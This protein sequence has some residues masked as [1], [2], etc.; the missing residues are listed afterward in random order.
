[1][2]IAHANQETGSFTS[3][4]TAWTIARSIAVS[5]D[6]V[7]TLS[8]T[9]GGGTGT[10]VTPPS[11]WTLIAQANSGTTLATLV[12]RKV[13][14]NGGT[15]PSSYAFVVN[16]A[17]QG[18]WGLDR[19][20][21]VDLTTQLSGT[22][23]TNSG[24]STSPAGTAM[25]TADANAMVV[26][27]MGQA[28]G[29]AAITPPSGMAEAWERVDRC[30]EL[31]YVLQ[32][33]AG[34]TGTKT[35][36]ST[37]NITW[38]VVVFALK[39]AVAPTASIA[40][41][42]ASIFKSPCNWFTS[43]SSYM[44]TNYGGAYFRIKWTGTQIDMAVDVSALT[45]AGI[46]AGSYPKI[47]YT[48]DNGAWSGP[49]QLTSATTSVTLASGLTDTAHEVWMVVTDIGALAS[50]DRWTTPVAQV[51]ITGFTLS[52]AV[53]GST[54]TIST[55][56][57]RTKRMIVFGESNTEMVGTG[58]GA[59]VR[60]S[61]AWLLAQAFDCEV[62][63]CAQIGASW[64]RNISTGTNL[65]AFYNTGTPTNSTWNKLFSG[66]ARTF[67]DPDYIVIALGAGDGVT[68]SGGPIADATVQTNVE[69]V[70]PL[71][72]AQCAT[73][74]IFV[75]IPWG[76]YKRSAITAGVTTVADS[77]INVIDLGTGAEAG[78]TTNPTASFRSDDGRHPLPRTA[79]EFAA[80]EAKLMQSAIGGGSGRV[81]NG[82]LVHA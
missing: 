19:W 15:E 37:V 59:D 77:R 65:P 45:G 24:S 78:M 10:T 82:G 80:W 44:L 38:T 57:L 21:G 6:D 69:T 64:T 60:A 46:A 4:T 81:V 33:V 74:R 20:T 13:V 7:L 61:H 51:K 71:L 48:V 36:A 27:A 79:G 58:T 8:L 16:V 39:P 75:L 18:G 56:T 41:D 28:T 22:A 3:V 40:V 17:Q 2:A 55:P 62:G 43:G 30:A 29:V 68:D 72:R 54:P 23:S 11:G 47:A 35:A 14:T 76:G 67:I 9:M 52:G 73:A 32:A 49:T 42:N 70:L 66:Q 5:T 50:E 12:Y 31:A 1:M 25:T 63:M 26:F 34:T 53:G